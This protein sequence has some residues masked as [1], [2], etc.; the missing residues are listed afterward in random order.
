MI[1]ADDTCIR[2]MQMIHAFDTCIRYKAHTRVRLY[3]QSTRIYIMSC[4]FYKRAVLLF[5]KYL[6][7][8]AQPP[9]K[10]GGLLGGTVCPLKKCVANA[11]PDQRRANKSEHRSNKSEQTCRVMRL[12]YVLTPVRSLWRSRARTCKACAEWPADGGSPTHPHVAQLAQY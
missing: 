2:Y 10:G 11:E 9:A 8:S 3:S 12:A 6:C 7:R 5:Y 4:G 1:H